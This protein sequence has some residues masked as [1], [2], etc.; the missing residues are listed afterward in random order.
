MFCRFGG[1][2]PDSQR[3]ELP[4][5]LVLRF[6][7]GQLLDVGTV[8]RQIVVA[9]DLLCCL[10]GPLFRSFRVKFFWSGGS[11]PSVGGS[12]IGPSLAPARY[13][14]TTV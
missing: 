6:H 11:G 14:T 9:D 7:L 3:Y 8:S 13:I 2:E 4:Q 12:A 10:R 1:V 5:D